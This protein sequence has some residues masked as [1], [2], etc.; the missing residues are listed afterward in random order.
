MYLSKH[1][2]DW[3][4]AKI[5][6]ELYGLDLLTPNS[7]DDYHNFFTF[8]EEVRGLPKSVHVGLTNK[9]V[10]EDSWYNARTGEYVDFLFDWENATPTDPANCMSFDNYPFG[11]PGFQVLKCVGV[12]KQFICQKIVKT[13]EGLN[14]KVKI[15]K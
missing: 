3:V 9:G 10:E 2:L 4:R 1:E 5:T 7:E 8:W 14:F 13:V 15:I 11:T 12:P 6:C